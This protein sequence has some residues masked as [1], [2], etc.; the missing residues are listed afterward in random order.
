MT[1]N[2]DFDLDWPHG[3]QTRAGQKARIL[4]RDL[5]SP[6]YPLAVAIAY[7]ENEGYEKLEKYT[8]DG[9]YYHNYQAE[10]SPAIR[11][12]IQKEASHAEV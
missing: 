9:R 3:H 10:Q 7:L 6:H 8:L 5:S 2:P 11:A 12:L 1:T 4:A